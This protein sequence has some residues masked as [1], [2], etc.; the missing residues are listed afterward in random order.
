[1][2]KAVTILPIFDKAATLRVD[3]VPTDVIFGCEA[4]MSEPV[5]AVR[6]ERPETLSEVRIP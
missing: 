3:S 5:S 2:A 6:L 1:L 4:V